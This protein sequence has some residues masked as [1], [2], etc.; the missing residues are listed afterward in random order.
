MEG[1]VKLRLVPLVI[2]DVGFERA[3]VFR[4]HLFWK[5]VGSVALE[6]MANWGM[7][8][9]IDRVLQSS[10]A[11]VPVVS[12]VLKNA[13]SYGVYQ[14]RKDTMNYPFDSEAPLF[15]DTFKFGATFVF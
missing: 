9:F 6:G 5:W 1:G 14:L 11:A 3:I 10:P 7:D 13:L 8:A 12:F 15:L 4:R 2:I